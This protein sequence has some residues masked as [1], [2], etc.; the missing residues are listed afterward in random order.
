MTNHEQLWYL[1]YNY[2]R[3][4][5]NCWIKLLITIHMCYLGYNYLRNVVN[6]WI[7]LLI[8]IQMWYNYLR[9]IVNC[10][11]KLLITIQMWYISRSFLVEYYQF[12]SSTKNNYSN[13]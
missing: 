3:N 1:G 2:L 12:P 5:V 11:I 4:V 7:K 8:T 9:N 6:C 10:W 13:S